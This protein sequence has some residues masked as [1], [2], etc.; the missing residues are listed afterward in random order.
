[1]SD[2]APKPITLEELADLRARVTDVLTSKDY[3]ISYTLVLD[4]LA[5]LAEAYPEVFALI[6]S[7]ERRL[8]QAT[9]DAL[10]LEEQSR[11]GCPC[12]YTTPCHKQCSCVRPWMSGGCARCCRYG[13]EDYQKAQA[14]RIAKALSE[15]REK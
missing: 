2:D 7:L 8:A 9:R 5:Q 1:M 3:S 4:E 13:N 11:S 6:E 10:A 15:A 12:L 14:E